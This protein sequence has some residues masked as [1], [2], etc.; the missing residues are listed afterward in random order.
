MYFTQAG[1]PNSLFTV[2]DRLS[3]KIS[4][5][6]L[7]DNPTNFRLGLGSLVYPFVESEI[8]VCIPCFLIPL[9]LFLWGIIKPILRWFNKPVD[10]S[11]DQNTD[12]QICSMLSSCPCISKNKKVP[13]QTDSETSIKEPLKAS[14]TDKKNL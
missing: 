13:D 7:K 5:N 3:S 11:G 2:R 9:L 6:I 12:D 1:C 10:N 8:M 14:D 4:L